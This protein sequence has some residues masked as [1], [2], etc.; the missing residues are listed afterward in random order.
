MSGLESEI[1]RVATCCQ[2]DLYAGFLEGLEEC[3]NAG[4]GLR[5]GEVFALQGGGLGDVVG[6]GHGELGP[7]VE[8]FVG[9]VGRGGVLDSVG[10]WEEWVV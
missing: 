4:E 2:G 8:D 3:G 5:A 9:L 6:A 7:G 10:I 1:Q